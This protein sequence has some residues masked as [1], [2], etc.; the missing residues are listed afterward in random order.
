MDL[1]NALCRPACLLAGGVFLCLATLVLPARSQ[2]NSSDLTNQSI[3]DL[4]NIEVTSV[5]KTEQTLSRTASAVFVISPEDIRRSGATNIPD[6]LRMVPGMDV[7]Q[8]NGNT[9]A[10]SARGFNARFSNELL[11]LVDGRPVYTETFGGV[12]WDVLDLPL[13]EMCIRDR[14]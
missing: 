6:L 14:N 7:S 3:E 10:V 8:I 9:W 12:Y 1:C 5:S 4:M 13:E 11:V 2:Q